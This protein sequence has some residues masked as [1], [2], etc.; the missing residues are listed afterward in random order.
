MNDWSQEN[1]HLSTQRLTRENLPIAAI[2]DINGV[3]FRTCG[4]LVRREHLD[5]HPHHVLQEKEHKDL[6]TQLV[7]LLF[8]LV[9]RDGS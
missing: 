8:S 9:P 4:R 5:V 2:K 1:L 3:T 6:S 7:F